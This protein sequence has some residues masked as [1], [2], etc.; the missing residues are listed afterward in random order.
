M[1]SLR[2]MVQHIAHATW[3][4]VRSDTMQ[5]TYYEHHMHMVYGMWSVVCKVILSYH[6]TMDTQEHSSR[7]S[8]CASMLV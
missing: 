1:V 4:A 2:Y 8:L 3:D 7:S 5:G 6:L